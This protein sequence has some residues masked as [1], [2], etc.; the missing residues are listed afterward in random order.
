MTP[1]RAPHQPNY[2]LRRVGNKLRRYCWTC[3]KAAKARWAAKNRA[4]T[5]G[6][7][8]RSAKKN[9]EAR[10]MYQREYRARRRAG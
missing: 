9:H 8:R 4:K 1:H 3:A 7:R 6:I 5:L 10:I 2:T